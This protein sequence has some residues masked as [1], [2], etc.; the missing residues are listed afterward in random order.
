MLIPLPEMLVLHS[1]AQLLL[2]TA[3]GLS[4]S[5]ASLGKSWLPNLDEVGQA[6]QLHVLSACCCLFSSTYKGWN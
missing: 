5:V 6:L 4:I 3:S 1:A 2:H